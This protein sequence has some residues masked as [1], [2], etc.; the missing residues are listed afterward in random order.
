MKTVCETSGV[1]LLFD[2]AEEKFVVIREG[3]ILL[4]TDNPCNAVVIWGDV[5]T[6]VLLR[7]VGGWC[8]KRGRNRYTGEESVP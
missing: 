3:K 5:A 7:R 1:Q 2:E 4:E 8:E 6:A